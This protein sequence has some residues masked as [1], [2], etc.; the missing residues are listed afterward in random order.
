MHC[1]AFMLLAK[2]MRRGDGLTVADYNI[3]NFS[4]VFVILRLQ[5]GW[6]PLEAVRTRKQTLTALPPHITVTSRANEPCMIT[7]DDD[8]KTKRAKMPCGHVIGKILRM[9]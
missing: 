7:L 9:L 4:T 2:A 8:T 6:D 5:G 3:A 1:V